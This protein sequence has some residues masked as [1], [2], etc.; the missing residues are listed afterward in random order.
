MSI[1]RDARND[2]PHAV[3]H[4]FDGVA[5]RAKQLLGFGQGIGGCVE[6]RRNLYPL[7]RPEKPG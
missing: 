7:Q 3:L 4:N 5:E 6:C 1:A 2:Q